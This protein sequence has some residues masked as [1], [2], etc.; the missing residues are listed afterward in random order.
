MVL[1]RMKLPF[2]RRVKLAQGLWLLSWTATLAGA[3]TFTLGCLLK[4]E[5]QRRAEVM[6]NTE[7]HVVPNT[8]MVVSL[9]SLGINYFAGRVC[10][11][12]LD[13]GRFP[14]WKA[15]M[16]P[17][18]GASLFFTLLMLIPV[19]ISYAM[20]G[21]LESSLEIGLK[22]G[23]RF[24]K[25]TDT[26]GRC[27]QKQIIDRL[28]MEFKCCGNTDYKDWFQV[29]WVSN[30]YLDFSSKE[31]KDR[32]R[33][34]VDG[35]FLFDGVPFSCC[36][37]SSPR[38]CI[39][40]RLNNNSAH[41]NYEHQTEELNIYARGCREALVTYY[42]GLMNSIGAGVLSVF[43]VQ[44]SVLVSLRYLQTAMEAVAGQEN[45]EIE[46][47]GYLLENG[48]KEIVMEYLNRLLAFVK[49]NQVGGE[50]VRA[51]AWPTPA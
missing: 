8:L 1:M 17:Y 11:E 6:D 5:L 28:Q 46:T 36:N 15:F 37:P 27:F 35:R 14:R 16:K 49:L 21:N 39:Q 12:A 10:Q 34:N 38:P 19:I 20:K 3:L 31:V 50:E 24:Y 51:G 45:T 32:V 18:W 4:T 29:Q 7:I 22:N 44:S 13:A 40:D 2:E 30:H 48:M 23:I 26:P 9:A 47:E 33:S 43:L 41:Y 42:M 25:D